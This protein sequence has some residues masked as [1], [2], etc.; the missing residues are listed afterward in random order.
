MSV[1]DVRD[2]RQTVEAVR[3]DDPRASGASLVRFHA[4]CLDD[5]NPAFGFDPN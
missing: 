3:P 1:L 4:C 5:R 2:L